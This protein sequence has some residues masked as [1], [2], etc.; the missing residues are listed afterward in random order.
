M[1]PNL[2][3]WSINE[4]FAY[5]DTPVH[6]ILWIGIIHSNKIWIFVNTVIVKSA[7]VAQNK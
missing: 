2:F 5:N 7:V 1:V 3:A 6:P 4:F